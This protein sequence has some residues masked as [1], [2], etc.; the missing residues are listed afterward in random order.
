[1]TVVPRVTRRGGEW[2]ST[3]E[4]VFGKVTRDNW[5]ALQKVWNE[6]DYDVQNKLKR[7]LVPAWIPGEFRGG[8]ALANRMSFSGLLI[9]DL[10]GRDNP[11]W[12]VNGMKTVLKNWANEMGEPYCAYIGLSVR[13]HGLFAVLLVPDSAEDIVI[14]RN[15]AMAARSELAEKGLTADPACDN[16]IQSRYLS[17]D[18]ERV[19]RRNP[20]LWT[21]MAAPESSPPPPQQPTQL[22]HTARYDA[23]NGKLEEIVERIVC[24]AEMQNEPVFSSFAE[25][26]MLSMSLA[27]EFGEA[28]RQWFLRFSKVW[29]LVNGPQ[30]QDPD[31]FFTKSLR[32][33]RH[34]VGIGFLLGKAK[35]R[36]RQW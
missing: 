11:D 34:R 30:R 21:K 2:T 24:R 29:S 28:G 4:D 23:I 8:R 22:S 33:T 27:G 35:Q 26:W 32:D 13:R 7:E 12:T 1:M 17:F 20:G 3:I 25:W 31:K 5:N 18:E 36:L 19:I 10:D 6:P 14:F 9:L 15:L 16:P